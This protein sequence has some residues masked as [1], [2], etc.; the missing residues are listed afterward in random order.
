MQLREICRSESFECETSFG[1]ECLG[2]ELLEWKDSFGSD[3]DGRKGK[4]E[5]HKSLAE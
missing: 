1:M 2:V 4:G 3:L 5:M